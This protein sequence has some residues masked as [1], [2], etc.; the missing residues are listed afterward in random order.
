MK[1]KLA[2]III[3]FTLCACRTATERWL[4][5]LAGFKEL[6]TPAFRLQAM[7]VTPAAPDTAS[8]TYQVRIYPSRGGTDQ[9]TGFYYGMDSCFSLQSGKV[10]VKPSYFQPVNNGIAHCFEYLLSFPVTRSMRSGPA[11]LVYQ[12]RIIDGKRYILELNK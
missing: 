1:R 7:K 12:D 3:L 10:N 2:M 5:G 11:R 8:V 4:D 9:A 6:R